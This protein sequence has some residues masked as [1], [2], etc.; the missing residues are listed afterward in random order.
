MRYRGRTIVRP[1]SIAAYMVAVMLCLSSCVPKPVSSHDVITQ[2]ATDPQRT[3]MTVLVKYAFS[4][5][6]F[7]AAVEEKFPDIDLVQVGN[8]TRDMG[9]AEYQAR[10][11]HGDLPDVV[12]TWPLEAGEEYWDDRL[13]D[14]S[15]MEFTSRYNVSML[16]NIAKSGKLYYLPGPA[17]IRAIVYNKTLFKEN[18]WEVPQDYEGF[19][20]LCRTIEASGIRAIQL[21]FENSEVLDTA[22]VGYNYG[23]HF[24]TPQDIQWL[25][26]YNQ[27]KGRF[28]QQFEGA[29]TVFQDMIDAGVWRPSDLDK[30]YS[31]RERML[32]TRE[33]AMTE[34]SALLTEMGFEQTGTTDE[35]ALMPFF[36][37]GSNN[38]W[39]RLYMVCYIGLNKQLAEPVNKDKYNLV[40]KMM[41]FISTKEGQDALAADTGAMYSSLIG[42]SMPDNP[43]IEALLPAL[44]HGRCIIFPTLRNSSDALRKGLA[45][46]V[47]GELTKDEVAQMVDEQNLSPYV[48]DAPE[49]LG[50]ASENFTLT[51]TG[52]FVADVLRKWSGSEIALFLDN[53]KDGRCNGKGI[54]GRIY[55]GNVTKLDM[56][57]V[58]PDLKAGDKGELWTASITGENLIRVLEYSAEIVNGQNGWFYYPSG[59]KITFDPTAQQGKR[60]QRITTAE[61]ET[62]K[63]TDSFTIV[64][65]EGSVPVE[66]LDNL[67]KTG[68]N[69]Y[70]VVTQAIKEAGTIS[71]SHDGRLLIKGQQ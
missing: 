35:F 27:G 33:C 25:D 20:E 34:D 28:G 21:G 71:P 4:I 55:G 14:L 57:R 1:V 68:T 2:K 31:E 22:F 56:D 41:D 7:E 40:M 46:M 3:L 47:R 5:H 11:E 12:M 70:D 50:T 51:E 9:I 38:D 52:G 8:F 53:G 37:P 66:C 67:V 26:N 62:I 69:S 30:D 61:G 17:Q 39:A 60:V 43:K 42:A 13:M 63:P 6:A 24:S 19:L 65:T 29:L 49:V 54:S 58:M 15:G 59:L 36:N 64:V 10:I 18:G 23:E 45:G 16:N 44:N 48:M 32:F